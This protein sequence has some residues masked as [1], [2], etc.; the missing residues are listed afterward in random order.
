MRTCSTR[1]VTMLAVACVPAACPIAPLCPLR[2]PL[3]P[4][5]KLAFYEPAQ[6]IGDSP[7]TGVA[8]VQVDQRGPRAA[9]P[10]PVHQLTQRGPGYRTGVLPVWRRS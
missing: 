6:A 7:L 9:M 8:A 3:N 4:A 1:T 10:H 5:L 2:T